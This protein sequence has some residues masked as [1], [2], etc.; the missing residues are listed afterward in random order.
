MI[1]ALTA[2]RVMSTDRL[3]G[4]FGAADRLS[5]VEGRVPERPNQ[6]PEPTALS[7]TIRACARLAPAST[8]AHL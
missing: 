4:S 2:T 3:I 5:Q 8:V 7:V 1:E 6:S